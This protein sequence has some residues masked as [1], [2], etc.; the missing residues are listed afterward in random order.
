MLR[1]RGRASLRGRSGHC[2]RNRSSY[3]R[4]QILGGLRVFDDVVRNYARLEPPGA[5]T[6]SP[7]ASEGELW[8]RFRLYQVL[9]TSL[10]LTGA[11][12]RL[13]RCLDVGCGLG[14]SS[15]LLVDLGILPENITAVDIRP[16][17]VREAKRYNPAIRF[18]IVRPG[19]LLGSCPP[20][21]YD[22]CMQCTAFSSIGAPADRHFLA[23]EMAATVRSGGHIFWWD[24]MYANMFAGGDR[25]DPETYFA[26]MPV[27][28]R[29]EIP[30]R[31]T[32]CEALRRGRRFKR[33]LG[34]LQGVCGHFRTHCAVLFH[35]IAP[36]VAGAPKNAL[37]SR[38]RDRA[39]LGLRGSPSVVRQKSLD[40]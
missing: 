14:R 40:I 11:D 2:G 39:W 19:D 13:L 3:E 28:Y 38:E 17:V 15:R 34:L 33:V 16:D 10:R 24:R 23:R 12:I 37:M 27:L 18:A 30:V 36:P 8:H 26:S 21:S 31:P 4:S 1:L 20:G 5:D 32:L 9:A 6:W 25:L 29:S 35:R 22:F 7:V